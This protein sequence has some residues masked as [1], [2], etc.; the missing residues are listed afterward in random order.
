MIQYYMVAIEHYIKAGSLYCKKFCLSLIYTVIIC[1]ATQAGRVE[2]VSSEYCRLDF[3]RD[4]MSDL[5]GIYSG[6]IH[7]AIFK[8]LMDNINTLFLRF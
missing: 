3:Q 5:Q 4:M 2:A 1:R 6:L 7:T 8:Y